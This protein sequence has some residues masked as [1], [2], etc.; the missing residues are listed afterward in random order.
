MNEQEKWVDRIKR[1]RKFREDDF[2]A[3]FQVKKARQWFEGKQN[4]GNPENEWITINKIYSHLL[5]ELPFLYS[6]DPY[7][8]VKLKR[9][10]IPDPQAIADYE[11]K[12]KIRQAY[13]NYLKSEIKLKE[14]ARL[15]IMDAEF[16][17]GVAK[18]HYS[19]ERKENPDK[20]KPIYGENDE[21]L[22][23][24]SGSELLEPDTIAVNEKYRVTR[25]HPKHVFWD[26]DAGPLEDD[27]SW[28]AQRTYV[29]CEEAE[30]DPSLNK[31]AL[32]FA[33]KLHRERDDKKQQSAAVERPKDQKDGEVYE[34]YE[35]YDLKK[36]RWLKVA[37]GAKELVMK[38]KELPA[39]MDKHPFCIL[40]FTVRDES[41]YPIP[42]VSQALDPQREI[43]EARSKV[44]VHRKR[45]NRKYEINVN[46]LE[47][48]D[49]ADKLESGEDGTLIRV[50]G[51]GAVAPIRDAPLDQQSYMEIGALNND[52][53]EMMGRSGESVG[54]SDSDSATQAA[55]I[56]KRVEIREGDKLSLV[57]DW[58]IEIGRK[59]DHL[60]Q[61]NITRDEAVRVVGPSGESW[62]IVKAQDYEAIKGDYE[63]SVNVGSTVPRLP[64]VER[65]QWMALLQVI[66]GFPQLLTSKRF[67]KNMAEMHHI[68]DEAM[69]DEL[70][71]IGQ[72]IM[73]G[74]S[75][76][77]GS[78]PPPGS[79]MTNPITALL[80]A[81][82]G[83]YTGGGV[84]AS[85]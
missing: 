27:W 54:L 19:A 50:N 81:G 68:E 38:P 14:K 3:P 36:G 31:K 35:I 2:E 29:M 58:I 44:L 80:G 40:R 66:G 69:I 11:Q 18:V 73:A 74:Q 10:F 61:A 75:Q 16:E 6:I 85:V 26:E 48:P 57:T 22:M 79:G 42:P 20:G 28:I 5:S 33:T 60:V 55:L 15:G 45:F 24:E 67:L 71:Q 52:I 13:L 59:L 37:T 9:S 1:A 56:D 62:E 4:P 12:G 76:P 25:I 53:F 39:G 23:D 65:Q 77:T 30:D 43:N 72:M 82:M 51:I 84:N 17:Y 21:P 83:D 78:S 47:D 7:F 34:I 63:Y 64:Q 32:E 70:Y 41:P 8:Y 49:E 46:M